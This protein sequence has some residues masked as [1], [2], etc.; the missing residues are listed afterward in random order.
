MVMKNETENKKNTSEK[1]GVPLHP[2]FYCDRNRYAAGH[3]FIR[4]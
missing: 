2:D 1:A 4:H 3:A